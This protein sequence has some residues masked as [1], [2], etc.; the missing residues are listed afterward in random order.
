MLLTADVGAGME[1][2]QDLWVHIDHQVLLL[3]DLR[4]PGFDLLLDPD[5]EVVADAGVGDVDQ[6]LLWHLQDLLLD[7]QALPDLIVRL[8]ELE[9]VRRPEALVVRQVQVG[10]ILACDVVLGPRDNA[11]QQNQ[12]EGRR[13]LTL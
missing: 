13:A 5:A 4:V 11:E 12:Y 7:G 10:H 1:S 9:D 6:P 3:R 2:G 8:A